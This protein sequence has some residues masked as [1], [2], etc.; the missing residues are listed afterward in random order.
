MAQLANQQY[1]DFLHALNNGAYDR[2]SSQRQGNFP[3]QTGY[4]FN[5]WRLTGHNG[6]QLPECFPR[7]VIC[8][9]ALRVYQQIRN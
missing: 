1:L 3:S 7:L 2:R 5:E 4:P 9:P 6:R 8:Q